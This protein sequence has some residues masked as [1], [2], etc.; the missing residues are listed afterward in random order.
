MN[1]LQKTFLKVIV[2]AAI[3][4]ANMKSRDWPPLCVGYIYQPKR[5]KR[6]CHIKNEKN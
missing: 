5:P 4:N 3:A 2:K 6:K 1:N